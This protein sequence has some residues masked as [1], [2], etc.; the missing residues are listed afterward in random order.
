MSVFSVNSVYAQVSPLEQTF[1]ERVAMRELDKRCN[2]FS[3]YERRAMNAFVMQARGDILRQNWDLNRVNL[4]ISQAK[5]GVANKSC[6]DPM[7][8]SESNRLKKAYN[9][10][11]SQMLVQYKGEKNLWTASRAGV[12]NWRAWQ[13]VGGGV[14]VGYVLAQ[15]GLAFAVETN[16]TSIAGA[17]VYLRNSLKIGLPTQSMRGKPALRIGTDSYM[18]SYSI[19]AQ[20]KRSVESNMASGKLFVFSNDVTRKTANLDPRDYYEVELFDA[21]GNTNSYIVEVG[22]VITAF[23]FGAET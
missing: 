15:N 17:R 7:V 22:D 1:A 9:G 16:N 20:S 19:S 6:S 23:A 14:K 18:A 21:M 10:W 3:P 12:D 5:Q 11:K 8:L 13:D 4:L 2:L